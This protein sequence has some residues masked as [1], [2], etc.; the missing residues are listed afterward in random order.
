MVRNSYHLS[1]LNIILLLRILCHFF[2]SYGFTPESGHVFCVVIFIHHLACRSKDHL[3]IALCASMSVHTQM[4]PRE[5]AISSDYLLCV[6][7][8][9]VFSEWAVL[10]ERPLVEPRCSYNILSMLF[11]HIK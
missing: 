6:S 9:L 7:S 10:I 2:A 4:S 8:D 11:V 1:T 5:V 3:G